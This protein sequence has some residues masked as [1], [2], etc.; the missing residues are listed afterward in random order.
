M[1]ADEFDDFIRRNLPEPEIADQRVDRLIGA[2]LHAA[3]RTPQDLSPWLRWWRRFS[4]RMPHWQSALQFG[5]PILF[6]AMLGFS[7]GDAYAEDWPISQVSDLMLST[8]LY[9]PGQ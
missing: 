5:L 4:L 3:S 2:V 8:P 7:V 1:S 6:A 9:N